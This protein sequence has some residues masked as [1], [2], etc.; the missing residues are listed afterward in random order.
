MGKR[1]DVTCSSKIK[2]IFVTAVRNYTEVAFPA[3]GTDCALVARESLFDTLTEFEREYSQSKGGHASYNK[4]LRAM[5]KEG[6]RL[7]YQLAAADLGHDCPH[8]CTLLLEVAEGIAHTDEELAVAQAAD[9]Q[10]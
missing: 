2:E 1:I 9:S 4:R 7:H 10:T 5:V 3:G 8:E 6:I